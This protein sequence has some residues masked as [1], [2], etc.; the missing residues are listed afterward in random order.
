MFAQIIHII[1]WVDITFGFQNM[2]KND[3]NQM[4]ETLNQQRCYL[5]SDELIDMF[6]KTLTYNEIQKA[7]Q[8]LMKCFD[9]I[10]PHIIKDYQPLELLAI[11]RLFTNIIDTKSHITKTHSIGVASKA[12][13]MAC[14]YQYDDKEILKIFI[15]GAM[16]DLGKLVIERDVLEKPSKLTD[17]EYAYMQTHV[18]HTYQLL[19]EMDLGDIVHWAS[20]H[21]E[22]LDGTGYPFGK[23]A[24][25]LDFV[26]R[27][28]ACCDIYQALREQRAY[29]EAMNHSSAITIMRDMVK[30]GK[31]DE[32]IVEDMNRVFS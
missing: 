20:Y 32:N 13:L 2:S 9:E 27:L 29:K 18:Y 22:K 1:N 12:A 26:D 11:C 5:F 8:N 19:N 21:H 31:I 15:A 25:Q 7:Q 6:C 10:R 16:H 14:H 23:K 28:I 17:Q 4:I 24:E 3:Y 30:N